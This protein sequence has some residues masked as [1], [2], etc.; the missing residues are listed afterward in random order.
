MNPPY[1]G[2]LHLKILSRLISLYSDAE[3]VNLS[4]IR[5]LLDP[6]AE[7]KKN[8]DWKRFIDI[9]KK[10]EDLRVVTSK[11]AQNLFGADIAGDL[12]IYILSKKGGFDSTSLQNKLLKKIYTKTLEQCKD[13][14]ENKYNGVRVKFSKVFGK[15]GHGG[16]FDFII[17]QKL[18]YFVDGMKDG[19]L[20]YEHYNRNQ[21]TKETKEIPYS[22]KFDSEEEA[23]NFIQATSTKLGKYY[24]HNM[25]IDQNVYPYYYLW[26]DDYTHPW[27]DKD[28]YEY[29]GLT[30]DEI[31]E[32]ENEMA[33]II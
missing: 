16:D 12:G 8:S 1:S 5:W 24:Y 18:L 15:G 7:Y 26:L 17:W 6:L 3:I 10:I 30:D 22:V 21:F 4:P 32:I 2:N 29:F 25:S 28:L 13:W 19:K 33:Q 20:W 31:K 9:R 11:E 14:E 23:E 27:T